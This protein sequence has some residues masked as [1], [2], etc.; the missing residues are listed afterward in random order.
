ML[1]HMQLAAVYRRFSLDLVNSVVPTVLK[2][3]AASFEL[4]LGK[5]DTLDVMLAQCRPRRTIRVRQHCPFCPS[6]YS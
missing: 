2:M 6:R 5:A 1:S 4:G 3:A